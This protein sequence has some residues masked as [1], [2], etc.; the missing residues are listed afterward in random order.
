[1]KS[2]LNAIVYLRRGNQMNN[3][4][5]TLLFSVLIVSAACVTKKATDRPENLIQPAISNPGPQV[6]N[7][8][9]RLYD[10]V[11]ELINSATVEIRAN[12]R[13]YFSSNKLLPYIK[14]GKGK[15]T[16]QGLEDNFIMDENTVLAKIFCDITQ[17]GK[18]Y[19]AAFH[20]YLDMAEKR[21]IRQSL[22]Y[23]GNKA[24]GT[25]LFYDIRSFLS[26]RVIANTT[27]EERKS[28]T[29]YLQTLK[30]EPSG[31]RKQVW[32]LFNGDNGKTIYKI[33]ITLLPDGKGGTYFM[34]E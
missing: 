32:T 8:K 15:I 31:S 22:L 10:E 13:D 3:L 17:D 30:A 20:V 27:K 5:V 14:Q 34:M 24:I 21:V 12:I 9:H 23:I 6:I 19:K 29:I 2:K 4:L 33:D 28:S 26:G 18:N 7:M 16:I 1:M 25:V 11:S